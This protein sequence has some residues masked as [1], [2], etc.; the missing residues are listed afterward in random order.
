MKREDGRKLFRAFLGNSRETAGEQR[1]MM[2][3]MAVPSR[4]RS[5]Y[6]MVEH[7]LSLDETAWYLYAW[8]RDP[9]AGFPGNR[10]WH[11]AFGRQSAG[12][13]RRS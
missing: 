11:T 1:A 10:S 6:S 12:E 3:Q 8:S 13:V 4:E 5:L 7:L 9:L 2:E